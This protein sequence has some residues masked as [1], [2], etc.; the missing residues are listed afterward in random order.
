[1]GHFIRTARIKEKAPAAGSLFAGIYRRFHPCNSPLMILS[2]MILSLPNPFR[3]S[4]GSNL[5]TAACFLPT[6]KHPEASGSIRK[7]KKFSIHPDSGRWQSTKIVP[8]RVIFSPSFHDLLAWPRKT[9]AQNSPPENDSMSF[10]R[11]RNL[12][13]SPS[14]S[15][16]C[17]KNSYHKERKDHQERSLR[18]FFSAI[19][20]FSAVSLFLVAALAALWNMESAP[21]VPL[22]GFAV[23]P[24]SAFS[25]CPLFC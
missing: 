15:S 11:W 13:H 18:C 19:F 6:R 3:E 24:V 4:R 10:L 14:T 25:S 8:D 5:F 23:W 12:Y 16:F 21:T 20:A 9:G 2:P 22:S 7:L 1:M 17:E